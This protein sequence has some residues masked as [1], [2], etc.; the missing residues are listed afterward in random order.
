MIPINDGV[1][2]PQKF[3]LE[4]FNPNLKRVLQ[5]YFGFPESLRTAHDDTALF[6]LWLI[7]RNSHVHSSPVYRKNNTKQYENTHSDQVGSRRLSPPA[8]VPVDFLEER[9]G[10]P[11]RTNTGCLAGR[12]SG[13]NTSGAP[14]QNFGTD[15]IIIS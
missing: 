8:K 11:G 2:L 5:F 15:H 3:G 9:H 6:L 12:T 14:V 10:C 4:L 1:S 7:F 13:C